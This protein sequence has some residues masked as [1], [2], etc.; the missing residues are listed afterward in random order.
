MKILT[1]EWIG[2][3]PSCFGIKYAHLYHP[4]PHHLKT[5]NISKYNNLRIYHQEV[6]NMYFR[7]S[8]KV[9]WPT[10]DPKSQKEYRGREDNL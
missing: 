4:L 5:P 1:S 9:L 10:A 3:K 8:L 7:H 2:V 6:R